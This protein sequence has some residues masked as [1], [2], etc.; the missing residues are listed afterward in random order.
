[1]A[2]KGN[3]KT[4]AIADILQWLSLGN[5]TGTLTII[6]QNI[7][8]KIYFRDGKIISA[9]SNDKREY[10]GAYLINNGLIDEESLKEALETHKEKK[11]ILGRYLVRKGIIEEETMINILKTKVEETIYSLFLWDNGEFQ[12]YD[13]ELPEK[14][15]FP[16]TIGIDWIIMEGIRRVDEFNEIKSIFNSTNIVFQTDPLVVKETDQKTP[17]HEKILSMINSE[18]SID[19]IIENVV[20]SEYEILTVL[21][22]YYDKK[23]LK[24]IGEKIVIDEPED[25][26]LNRINELM[27]KGL[28]AH[29]AG[30]LKEA[31]DYF[32]QILKI[33]PTNSNAQLLISTVEKEQSKSLSADVFSMENVPYLKKDLHDLMNKNFT[34]EE[35]FI[36]SY[37]NG[38]NSIKDIKLLSALKEDIIISFIKALLSQNIIAFKNK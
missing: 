26:D 35:G 31:I 16:I 20:A 28:E 6:N 5:K 24:I 1:M 10:L 33:N 22:E 3:L 27:E 11:E 36:L 38:K 12:F 37:I 30:N 18:N 17:L 4:M 15:L 29:R 7:I 13:N 2:L 21:H 19:D 8:K 34:A 25:E 32:K 14:T 23:Y 9:S